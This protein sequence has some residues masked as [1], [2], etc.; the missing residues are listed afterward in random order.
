MMLLDVGGGLDRLDESRL[1]LFVGQAFLIVEDDDVANARQPLLEVVADAKDLFD[2]DRRTG[3]RLLLLQQTALDALGDRNLALAGEKWD[4]GHL[5]QVHAHGIVRLLE[6]AG[7]K[8]EL[9]LFPVGSLLLDLVPRILEELLVRFADLDAFG[10]DDVENGLDL[11]RRADLGRQ[12]AIDVVVGQVLL[13]F[14]HFE[15]FFDLIRV[16]LV[17]RQV[18]YP[19]S[20]TVAVP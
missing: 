19:P 7:G 14:A 10:A 1:D 12:Q 2:G 5:A 3:D 15:K 9:A 13:L 4:D 18:P 11:V 16:F 20:L 6:R 8:V 17:D